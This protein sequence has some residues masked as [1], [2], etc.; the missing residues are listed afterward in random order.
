MDKL[1]KDEIVYNKAEMYIRERMPE[2]AK[3]FFKYKKDILKPSSYYIYAIDIAYFFDY[4][5]DND[6]FPNMKLSDLSKITTDVIEEYIANTRT[7]PYKNGKKVIS[8]RTERR[9]I[10]ILSSFFDYYAQMDFIPYNPLSKINRPHVPVG[11]GKGSDFIENLN[12]LDFVLNGHLPNKA[13]KRQEKLRN[14][15]NKAGKRQEKLRNRDAAMIA[16]MMSTGIKSSE[17]VALD[18]SDIDLEHNKI[19]I[20]TRKFP[21]EIYFSKYM[22]EILS[23]Y[24]NDRLKMIPVYGHDNALFLSSQMKRL[25]LRSLEYVLKKYSTLLFSDGRSITP[26][27]LKNAF[28]F[29]SFEQTENLYNAAAINGMTPESLLKYYLPYLEQ[30]EGK[31]GISFNPTT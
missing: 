25:E 21:N 27:D 1:S 17:C 28:R 30:F 20:K 13:G 22:A 5:K 9:K 4:L 18:I 29:N 15:P 3:R 2:F 8:D 23:N 11:A 19:A 16:L 24:L 6:R 31:K 10:C 14:L 12:L 7:L 26:R